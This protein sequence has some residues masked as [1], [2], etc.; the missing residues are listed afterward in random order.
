MQY[1]P[2]A[3]FLLKSAKHEVKILPIPFAHNGHLLQTLEIM[4]DM[5]HNR[6]E[7]ANNK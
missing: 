2:R 3:N 5:C 4:C 7:K 1:I 6:I